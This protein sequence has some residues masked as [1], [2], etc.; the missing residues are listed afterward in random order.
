MD[1]SCKD[2]KAVTTTTHLKM[3]VLTKPGLTAVAMI[4]LLCWNLRC[5][6]NVN[7]M[8]QSLD[9]AYWQ[10]LQAYRINKIGARRQ[11]KEQHGWLT[12]PYR[13]NSSC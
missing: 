4:P 11:E 10:N 7:K 12:R 6:S 5:S 3:D 13:R 8:L 9:R 2:A 1:T